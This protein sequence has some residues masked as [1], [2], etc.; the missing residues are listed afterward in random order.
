[1]FLLGSRQQTKEGTKEL[2][3]QLGTP[4]ATRNGEFACLAPT[5]EPAPFYQQHEKSAHEKSGLARE[6]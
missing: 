4:Q 2:L 6:R 5:L 3:R 1:M